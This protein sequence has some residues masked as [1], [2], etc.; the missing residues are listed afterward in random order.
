[1]DRFAPRASR[2]RS[3]LEWMC[4]CLSPGR[5]WPIVDGAGSLD[6]LVRVYIR[7]VTRVRGRFFH[8]RGRARAIV[9]VVFLCVVCVS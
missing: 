2:A 7:G 3:A 9:D 8:A 1:M 6:L 5:D 4:V